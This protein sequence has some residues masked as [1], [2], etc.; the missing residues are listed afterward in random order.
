MGSAA[1]SKPAGT[2]EAAEE[3]LGAATVQSIEYSGTGKWFQFGQAPN[4]TLPWPPFDVS[5][6][7]A[8]VNYA[9]PA[10][11]VEMVRKQTLEPPRVR[12]AP[13]EQ[14]PVQ[15]VSGTF[16]WNLA[17]PA[18][19]AA[20]TPPA[21][22]AQPAAVAERTMEIWATPHGFL[23]AARAN[24]A[25]SEPANGGS[26]VSFTV[27]GKDKYVGTINAQNQVEKVQTWIDNPVLGDTLVETTYSDYKDF[28]G[29]MFPG[30]I[31]RTQGGHP[32]LDINVSEVKAESAGRYSGAGER[33]QLHARLRSKSTS[34][35][36]RTASTT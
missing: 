20:G 33:A 21:A 1:C 35:S 26:T 36:S 34:R 10:A 15:V 23:K 18:G 28:G 31:V 12:P 2:L 14:R 32:V 8:A 30:H 24:S 6:F 27:G 4:P 13:V 16:A 22:Q 25:T 3:T 29:V 17:A 19:A 7:K 11:Q 5:S 9:T